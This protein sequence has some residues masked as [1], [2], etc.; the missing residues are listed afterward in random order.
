MWIYLRK[1]SLKLEKSMNIIIIECLDKSMKRSEKKRLT[2]TDT[3]V[4]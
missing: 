4:S 1:K 2:S 3:I